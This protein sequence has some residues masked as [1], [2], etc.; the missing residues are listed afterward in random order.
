MDSCQIYNVKKVDFPH[1]IKT[2]VPGSKS[3][4]NRALLIG[5]M[6]KGTSVIKGV[7]FSDDSRHVMQ[8]LYDLGFPIHIDEENATVT[9]E[10]YDGDIPNKEAEIYV[11]SAGTAA[12]FLT[13]FLGLSKG[14]YHMTCS[15]QMKKR[16]MKELLMALEEMGSEIY[17]EEEPYC[18]PFT[19][20]NFECKKSKVTIDVDKSSQFLSAV[21]ICLPLLPQNFMVKISGNHGMAYVNMTMRMMQHFGVVV[22]RTITGA[23]RRKQEM[24]YKAMEYDIEPDVSAACYFYA[25][26]PLLHVNVKVKNIHMDCLQGDIKFLKVL[27]RMGCKLEEEKDG[28]LLMPP[29]EKFSGGSFDLSAFSDQALTL[30]A[31][32]PFTK[33]KVCLMNVGH[34]RYQEC[35]RIKAIVSNLGKMGIAAVEQGNNVF[36]LP[37]EPKAAKIET[38]GDHR[39]AMA[40]SL[41]GTV[42]DGIEI[43]NPA[44][45]KKTFE[46]YFEV[47]EQSIY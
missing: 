20:G 5:A 1:D 25:L 9:I 47:L 14:R 7:L 16:P 36:I 34:I 10:G 8:A 40:F 41:V 23:Y 46:N 28:V 19:I 31:I 35:D 33:S 43:E 45:T 17:Y 39:V 2:E 27:V 38:F 3:I 15:E 32:A 24:N 13:A 37:G 21:L 6:A 22:E 30:A 18:F 44:C 12:R 26:C 42:V 29:K 4:T 11:G